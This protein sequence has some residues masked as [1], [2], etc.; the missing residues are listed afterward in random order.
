MNEMTRLGSASVESYRARFTT[1]EFLRMCE[2]GAFGDMK[3]ELVDGEIERLNLPM[4]EHG[5]LQALV[6]FEL[7][8]VLG[9]EAID[10]VRGEVAVDVGHNTVLAGDVTLYRRAMSGVSWLKPDDVLLLAEISVTTLRRDLGMKRG[11][12]AAAGIPLYWVIDSAH[13]TVHVHAEPIDGEYTDVRTVRFGDPLAVPGS[14]ATII[15]S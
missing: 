13:R 1:A 15:V 3:V 11:K 10:R 5:R 9:R 12:Y 7:L 14:D 8:R 6:M 4:N 2:V